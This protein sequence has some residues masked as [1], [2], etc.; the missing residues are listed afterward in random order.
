LLPLSPPLLTSYLGCLEVIILQ[1]DLLS[2]EIP[3]VVSGRTSLSPEESTE[4]ATNP[5][6]TG[7]YSLSISYTLLKVGGFPNI[8][9]NVDCL[10]VNRFVRIY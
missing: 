7:T 4:G 3:D 6:E 9:P 2:A 8:S 1:G 10:I 5:G